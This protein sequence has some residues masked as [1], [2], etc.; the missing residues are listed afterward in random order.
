MKFLPALLVML[1]LSGCMAPN[2]PSPTITPLPTPVPTPQPSPN[3][4]ES[5]SLRAVKGAIASDREMA[6]ALA[7]VSAGFADCLRRDSTKV[8]TTEQ[9]REAWS[10]HALEF[11][12][13]GTPLFKRSPGL[14]GAVDRVIIDAMGGLDAKPLTPDLRTKGAAAFDEIAAACRG[15]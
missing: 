3:V 6:Q 7:G 11:Q 1:C 4:V 12:F 8:T 13:Q 9:L 2:L 15:I 14:G 5:E 10:T